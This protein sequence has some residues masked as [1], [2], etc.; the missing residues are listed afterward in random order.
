[1]ETDPTHATEN[2]KTVFEP[3]NLDTSDTSAIGKNLIIMC[4]SCS[5]VIWL[6]KEHTITHILEKVRGNN[7]TI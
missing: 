7:I 5:L 6:Y 2:D 1:M 3:Q 4:C